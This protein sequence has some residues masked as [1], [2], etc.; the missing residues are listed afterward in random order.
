M[1]DRRKTQGLVAINIAAVIFGSAA[2]Y[3]KLNV[4]PVWIVAMRALFACA[5]LLA[6]AAY[7]SKLRPLDKGLWPATLSSGAILAVHWLS[8][9]AAVQ[10]AGIAIATLTFAV[11]PLFTLML[12]AIRLGRRMTLAEVGAGLVIILAVLL[13][14]DA[15][16]YGSNKALG[17]F[18]GIASALSFA[19]FG[20]A[21]KRLG[22][23]LSPLLVSLYQNAM[24]GVLLAPL[25]PFAGPA[26]RGAFEWSCLALLGVVTTAVMHQLYFFALQRLSAGV[27]SGFVALEPVYAIL[28]AAAI[29]GEPVTLRVGLS[30]ALIISSSLILLRED[31]K[32]VLPACP[33]G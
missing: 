31:R 1:S 33:A 28:M 25:L 21:S 5:A 29:F 14:V 26:P 18:A 7:R 6:M 9:F 32:S 22:Q 10:L 4:S 13:L 20:I 2:L 27:C 15:R 23:V 8:F 12:D 19:W 3:G 17:A 30:A 16:F 24:V 11:F